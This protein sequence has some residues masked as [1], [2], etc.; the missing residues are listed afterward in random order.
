M[1]RI[2]NIDTKA[3]TIRVSNGKD[4]LEWFTTDTGSHVPLK[5]GQSKA[6]AIKEHFGDGTKK[7]EPE[8]KSA[9]QKLK[10]SGDDGWKPIKDGSHYNFIDKGNWAKRDYSYIYVPDNDDDL[11]NTGEIEEDT[12]H[13]DHVTAK[14]YKDGKLVGHEIFDGAG[15]KRDNMEYAIK[16]VVGKL[17]K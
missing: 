5:K 3:R 8:K 4:D 12:F 17:K 14:V 13:R 10:D 9:A 6:E 1:V 15:S 2:I 7:Q 11:S 16:Y